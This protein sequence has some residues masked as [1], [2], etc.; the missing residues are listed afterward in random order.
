MTA[1]DLL[2]GGVLVA[3]LLVLAYVTAYCLLQLRLLGS[4]LRDRR[5]PPPPPRRPARWPRVTVQVPLYNERY[6]ATRVIDAVCGFDYPADRLQVQV[7]DDSTDDTVAIVAHCVMRWRAAGVDVEHVRRERRRGFKAGA[8]ADAMPGV[9]GE[10]VAIF[11]ADFVPAPDFLKASVPHFDA[12]EVGVVQSRWAHLNEDYSLITRL[13]ALQLNVHFTVEQRGRRAAGLF[14]QFNGTAGLWRRTCI[15]DAG[16]WRALTLT[17]DLDL[18]VRAQLRGWRI[19]YLEHNLAPAELPMEMSAFKSQQHRWMKGGAECSRILLPQVWRAPRLTFA[20][21]VHSTAHLLGSSIFVFV[22]LIGVLS[23]P[24]AFAVVHF[25]LHPALFSVF[26]SAT[27]AVGAVYWVANVRASWRERATGESTWRF[28][29]LF[30]AFLSLS[31]GLSLHNGLAVLQGFWGK[32]SDFVRTPKFALDGAGARALDELAANVYRG[33]RWSWITVGEGALAL[34]FAVATAVGIASGHTFFTVFHAML[35]VGYGAIFGY[36]VRHA[37]L[38]ARPA[39]AVAPPVPSSV[40]G[41][42]RARAVPR[43][44]SVGADV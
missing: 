19:R 44:R 23:L 35:A 18:S 13:Q 15:E 41:C 31:M 17:E 10:Y 40:H 27:L 37:S 43:R 42:E 6:V 9:T 28:L 16:G 4:Y 25:G 32:R 33:R 34:A 20:E 1:P 26:L 14:L 22:F 2:Y 12:P 8:L 36:T 7:L 38:R 39:V 30:P 24:T 11:D 21:K 29:V 3:Y 5:D